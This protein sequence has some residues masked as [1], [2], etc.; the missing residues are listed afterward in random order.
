MSFVM[1]ISIFL[2]CSCKLKPIHRI[3]IDAFSVPYS[4][5]TTVELITSIASPTRLT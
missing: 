1:T 4:F 5:N 3:A 2:N